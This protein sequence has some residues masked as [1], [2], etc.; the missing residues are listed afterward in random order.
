[1]LH[2]TENHVLVRNFCNKVK[3]ALPYQQRFKSGK[4]HGEH[5]KLSAE[6]LRGLCFRNKTTKDRQVAQPLFILIP[7]RIRW[8]IFSTLFA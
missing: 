8:N 2:D 7:E 5:I 1:M 3:N 6:N 4:D